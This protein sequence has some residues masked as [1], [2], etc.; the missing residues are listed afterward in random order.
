M[1]SSRDPLC[2]ANDVHSVGKNL[3]IMKRNSL[4]I[5]GTH[6]EQSDSKKK[7]VYSRV[8]QADRQYNKEIFHK[9]KDFYRINERTSLSCDSSPAS[10]SNDVQ[11]KTKG[12]N[13]SGE[14]MKGE[15]E[16][17]KNDL[18]DEKL[19]KNIGKP[20]IKKRKK[21]LHEMTCVPSESNSKSKRQVGRGTDGKEPIESDHNERDNK[22]FSP[23]EVTCREDLPTRNLVQREDKVDDSKEVIEQDGRQADPVVNRRS[24]TSSP[25]NE[26]TEGAGNKEGNELN[27]GCTIREEKISGQISFGGQIITP[28]GNYKDELCHVY[29]NNLEV[30]SGR[31][32]GDHIA[33]P[34]KRLTSVASDKENGENKKDELATVDS[35][36]G[37]REN[38]PIKRSH[39]SGED[40]ASI[41]T[42]SCEEQMNEKTESK[43][44][45]NSNIG[46]ANGSSEATF[47]KTLKRVLNGSNSIVKNSIVEKKKKIRSIHNEIL[48]LISADSLASKGELMNCGINSLGRNDVTVDE[49]SQREKQLHTEVNEKE[50]KEGYLQID[51]QTG[52]IEE[53]PLISPSEER[54]ILEE[55][56]LVSCD[57]RGS[58]KKGVYQ[59]DYENDGSVQSKGVAVY[60]KKDRLIEKCIN[61]YRSKN[62]SKNCVKMPQKGG[63]YKENPPRGGRISWKPQPR[64]SLLKKV[65][66]IYEREK[67]TLEINRKYLNKYGYFKVILSTYTRNDLLKMNEHGVD[68]GLSRILFSHDIIKKI[69]RI[70]FKTVIKALDFYGYVYD[71]TFLKRLSNKVTMNEWLCNAIFFQ[72]IFTT[73]ILNV[74]IFFDLVYHFLYLNPAFIYFF[75]SKNG[76]NYVK[77]FSL[78]DRYKAL[79]LVNKVVAQLKIIR[80]ST[81]SVV[82]FLFGFFSNTKDGEEAKKGGRKKALHGDE[83]RKKGNSADVAVK[84]V[85]VKDM[86]V[87]NVTVKDVT[88]AEWEALI[89]QNN[90]LRRKP[91]G[92]KENT[93]VYIKNTKFKKIGLRNILNKIWE[94]TNL[95]VK[96]EVY[97]GNNF[98]VRKKLRENRAH[99]L[100][101][102][103]NLLFDSN[104]TTSTYGS[105]SFGDDQ[106]EEGEPGYSLDKSGQINFGINEKMSDSLHQS[107]YHLWRYPYGGENS[108]GVDNVDGGDNVDGVDNA[109]GGDN[110]DGA[111]NVDGGDNIDGV[112]NADVRDNVISCDE[113]RATKTFHSLDCVPNIS[114][115]LFSQEG[116][117]FQR[118]DSYL[119]LCFKEEEKCDT[120]K[121]V[122]DL[123]Y[124][125]IRV[126]YKENKINYYNCFDVNLKV[127]LE[128]CLL[129]D[130]KYNISKE[131]DYTS[132]FFPV[133]PHNPDYFGY[134][135]GTN[136]KKEMNKI[137]KSLVMK[138]RGEMG[139]K[140][141]AI[142]L[143]RMNSK[144]T[145]CGEY[146]TKGTMHE[147]KKKKKFLFSKLHC[148]LNSAKKNS[149]R[150]DSQEWKEDKIRNVD[151][152][153]IKDCC[154]VLSV[155]IYP[156]RTLALYILYNA[157]YE[158]NNTKF[159]ELYSSS[160]NK[161]TKEWLLLFLLPNFVNKCIHKVTYPLKLTKNIFSE[162]NEFYEDFFSNEYLKINDIEKIIIYTKNNSDD[163]ME[164]CPF[165][166]CYLWLKF[167]KYRI[168][169]WISSKINE[170]LFTF[171]FA[172]F[173]LSKYFSNF[174]LFIQLFHTCL[175]IDHMYLCKSHF[176]VSLKHNLSFLHESLVNVL[177]SPPQR[178]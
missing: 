137:R 128:E 112:D 126:S 149:H 22:T 48:S 51:N 100:N 107:R 8:L 41:N 66:L 70:N 127:Y 53:Y 117:S 167:T 76:G 17:A 104:G 178:W 134:Q 71:N 52:M 143:S 58:L 173:L 155:K 165:S 86:T 152:M 159:V 10:S 177:F 78:Y 109:N 61:G 118:E 24:D 103:N 60:H 32:S 142:V 124:L 54:I 67:K 135:I 44:K 89:N 105:Y 45:R 96:E 59:V 88:M 119:T 95:Y 166:F 74:G 4:H 57:E 157:L 84:D 79:R 94:K 5:F 131:G 161:E 93:H 37:Q 162:S 49:G 114:F 39:C 113:R 121:Y 176:Y 43:E 64:R 3:G 62:E 9:M 1:Q 170:V 156:M 154:F 25:L 153:K 147:E 75:F 138:E 90:H 85:A 130:V 20:F 120:E 81:D 108:D 23:E 141:T 56:K 140:S 65:K 101:M 77:K 123:T 2:D 35:Y 26:Y 13:P 174:I 168:D 69:N 16:K 63:N 133:W 6:S 132:A 7:Q 30:G 46:C 72:K 163:D 145:K 146:G 31:K 125:G 47:R 34:K 115:D 40:K 111:D 50:G 83:P 169:R 99:Y 28:Y 80:P 172:N 116:D 73:K 55:Y 18:V 19:E 29:C 175:D 27:G 21:L 91:K 42:A 158:D 122:K 171:P 92:G 38:M 12:E 164:I 144:A 150:R 139:K 129:A 87:K 160:L 148:G 110:V 68:F 36:D 151:H 106:D 82:N 136:I 11:K 15:G 98:T 102:L 97:Y 33:V 14:K